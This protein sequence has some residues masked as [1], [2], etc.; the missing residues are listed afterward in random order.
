MLDSFVCGA[1]YVWT[2]DSVVLASNEKNITLDFPDSGSFQ[3][4]VTAYL[5][6]PLTGNI[7]DQEGPI[8]TTIR[9]VEQTADRRGPEGILCWNQIPFTWHDQKIMQSGDYKQT[10]QDSLSCCSF[11]SVR[12]FTVLERPTV[13]FV[14]CIGDSYTDTVTNQTFST[15][16]YNT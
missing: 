16:Q 14:G 5:G 6:N 12:L 9:V 3:L 13:Y 11:D 1:H 4:C 8:C 15:C 10:L 2:L 7:C